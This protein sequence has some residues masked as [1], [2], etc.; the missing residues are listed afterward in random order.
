MTCHC[1]NLGTETNE[2]VNKYHKPTT[3]LS[4]FSLGL[5]A[6]FFLLTSS[7]GLDQD[8]E[9]SIRKGNELSL[10]KVVLTLKPSGDPSESLAYRDGLESYLSEKLKRKV[11]VI[12][13][14]QGIAPEQSLLSGEIDLA[15][16]PLETAMREVKRGNLAILLE[17]YRVEGSAPKGVWLSRED[18]NYSGIDQLRGKAVAFSGNSSLPG[19]FLPVSDLAA[20]KLIGPE[21]ALTDYFSQTVFGTGDLSAVEKLLQ[22]EVEAAAVSDAILE[23]NGSLNKEQRDRLRILKELGPVPDSLLCV[24]ASVHESDRDLIKLA[25][26]ELNEDQPK[27]SERAFGGKFSPPGKEI[28][29]GGAVEALATEKAIKP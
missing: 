29:S 23:S 14:R 27:L 24:R 15:C 19:Y 9:S 25:I 5:I 13:P 28:H 26:V 12:V 2:T 20:G 10:K 18:G 22:G 21:V 7:C 17:T 8:E 1:F 11:E 6:C 16:L 4:V 3:S